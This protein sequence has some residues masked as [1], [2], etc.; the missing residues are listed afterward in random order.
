MSK[1][2]NNISQKYKSFIKNDNIIPYEYVIDYSNETLLTPYNLYCNKTQ[3]NISYKTLSNRFNSI[4]IPKITINDYLLRIKKYS[5]C[6]DECLISSFIHLNTLINKRRI[7]LSDYN[8]HRLLIVSI[9]VFTKFYDDEYYDNKM[10]AS[11]GGISLKEINILEIE[12]CE[13]IEYNLYIDLNEYKKNEE[14]FL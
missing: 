11:I 6:S 3:K 10:W 4:E 5:N 1:I 14:L 12:Y 7:R 8:I 9:M 2:I 13:L